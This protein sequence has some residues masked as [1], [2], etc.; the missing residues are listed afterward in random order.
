MRRN[1]KR[2]AIGI[3]LFL[4]MPLA[5]CF[6]LSGV[7]SED[8]LKR[9][10]ERMA[11]VARTTFA[12][13]YPALA[14]QIVEDTGVKEGICVEL[15]CG[16]GSLGLALV[17][18]TRLRVY[19]IDI[20]PY[21]VAIAQRNAVE[22]GLSERF[23]P[24]LG[25]ALNL[26]FKNDFADLIVSRGMIPFVEDKAAVF[27]EAFRVLRKGGVAYIGGGF[28][29]ML[30]ERTVSEIVRKS[31]W[32]DPAKLP[33]RRITKEQWEKHLKDAGIRNYRVIEDRYQSGSYGT[34]VM[35]KK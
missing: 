14:K 4:L 33:I 25:D 5:I 12:P 13:V 20:N 19:A 27:K 21:A 16:P 22:S 30:D 18:I 15:G 1:F 3:T 17:K 23:Y 2:L 31:I 8:E 26:P 10:A 29:R 9:S 35:F 7:E 32:A 6:C 11:E 34:W 28:S 24:M